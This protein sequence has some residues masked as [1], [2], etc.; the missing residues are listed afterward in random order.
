MSRTS[1]NRNVVAVE[2]VYRDYKP[3]VD[4][5]RAIRQM[6]ELTSPEY[7]AGLRSVVVRNSGSLNH[8]GRRAKTW[9]RKRKVV[10]RDC[11][12]VYHQKWK[13]EPAW[14]EVFVDNILDGWPRAF[15]WVPLVRDKLIG[16]AL[17]HEI[18]HHVH[19]T[20][21]PEH[22]EK[23]NVADKWRKR[24]GRAYMRK[25]YWYVFPLLV[26]A[27][28]IVRLVVPRRIWDSIPG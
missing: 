15:L 7:L 9:S 8:N 18:G 20:R 26:V 14:I 16:D 6:I 17:F 1:E 23:E 22:R 27:A 10:V 11:G 3:P 4:A 24:L 28:R 21:A 12:G 19:S 5:E 2:V 25:K 13:G